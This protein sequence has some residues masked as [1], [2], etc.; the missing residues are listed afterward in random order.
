LISCAPAAEYRPRLIKPNASTTAYVNAN[1]ELFEP[2]ALTAVDKSQL[3]G[4]LRDQHRICWSEIY[5]KLIAATSDPLYCEECNTYF[6]IAQAASCFFHPES[7]YKNIVTG[8]R[9]HPCCGM[10]FDF[11]GNYSLKAR[12]HGCKTKMHRPRGDKRML[13]ELLV[14]KWSRVVADH[15]PGLAANCPDLILKLESAEEPRSL[16]GEVG[17]SS[18]LPALIKVIPANQDEDDDILFEIHKRAVQALKSGR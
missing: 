11:A 1:G 16:N 17:L 13:L 6:T 10:E 5:L 12:P 15:L 2:H 8:I 14:P 18:F 3:I 4:F 9:R 7:S